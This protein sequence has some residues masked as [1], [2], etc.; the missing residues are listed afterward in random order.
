MEGQDCW[1]RNEVENLETE[2]G[3]QETEVGRQ[4]LE[5]RIYEIGIY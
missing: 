2:V 5:V 1:R 4:M 3:S